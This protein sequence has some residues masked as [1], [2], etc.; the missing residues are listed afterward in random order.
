[1]DQ[2]SDFLARPTTDVALINFLQN[3]ARP[4]RKRGVSG[5][6]DDQS[7]SELL[8]GVKRF[9]S[10]L[11]ESA[12]SQQFCLG[13]LLL[14]R[15]KACRSLGLPSNQPNRIHSRAV[16]SGSAYLN[17]RTIAVHLRSIPFPWSQEQVRLYGVLLRI[18]IIVAAARGIER[19][20]RSTLDD[21]PRLHHKDLIGATNG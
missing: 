11:L 15:S 5:G 10:H 19:L 18:E 20:M 17:F 8:A 2:P 12:E 21:P 14:P 9:F 13:V 7:I 16:P 4:E 6:R 3:R 1:M